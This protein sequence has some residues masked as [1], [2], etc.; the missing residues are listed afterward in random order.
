[1]VLI[2][3]NKELFTQAPGKVPCPNKIILRCCHPPCA[4]MVFKPSNLI[5]L[6]V[7][8]PSWL[9]SVFMSNYAHHLQ[10]LNDHLVDMLVTMSHCSF[11]VVGVQ[12][13]NVHCIKMP[14]RQ[15]YLRGG[16]DVKDRKDFQISYILH[17]G[18]SGFTSQ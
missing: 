4:R 2:I 9:D 12:V 17:S 6:S 13:K 3:P 14:L 1:M 18:A 7:L 8:L 15:L 5:Q 11:L 16:G 10:M